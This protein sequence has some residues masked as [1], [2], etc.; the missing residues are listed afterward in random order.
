VKIGVDGLNLR[1]DR[2][3]MGRLVRSV[4]SAARSAGHQVTL[5]SNERRPWREDAA[6]LAGVQLAPP[7]IA[8]RRAAFDAVW[9]PWNGIRFEAA[10]PSLAHI[11]DTFALDDPGGFFAR[12][13]VCGPLW[14]A[15][16][17]AS[18]VAADSRWAAGCI[19]RD[20]GIDLD[21]IVVIPLAPDAFFSPGPDAH[22]FGE[23][24]Y[25]LMVGAE[26]PRKNA[27]FLVAAFAGAFAQTDRPPLLVVAGALAAPAAA[28]ARELGVG[29]VNERPDDERLRALYRHANC[30]AVPS[31]A[32]GFGLVVVEAQACGAPVVASNH[33]ALLEAAGGA[34]ILLDPTDTSAWSEALRVVVNDET[35]NA[36]LRALSISRWGF[37]RRDGPARAILAELARLAG[38]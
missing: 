26:E 13:R 21:A 24:P 30:V 12:R 28:S 9:Y 3:G 34:A 6:L 25:V 31:L 7:R 18:R 4:L 10:S 27:A 36:R 38:A 1:N 37:R 15:A 32:E 33:G 20:L 16:R 29:I 14:R 11:H 5:L 22:P 17:D 8:H 35:E 19:H 2:R 23:M